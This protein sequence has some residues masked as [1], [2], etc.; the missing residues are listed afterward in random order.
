[1]TGKL[2]SLLCFLFAF[3]GTE[4]QNL[5]DFDIRVRDLISKMTIDEKISQ[6]HYQAHEISRLNIPAYNWGSECLHGVCADSVTVFPQ[7]IGLAATWDLPLMFQVS[8]AI[9]DEARVLYRKNKVGLT[10]WSPN[11]NLDRDPRWG[12]GQETYGEDPYLISRMGVAFVKGLQGEDSH[13][14][15]CV[16]GPKH[17]TAYSGPE[18]NRMEFNSIVSEC[19]LWET[20]LPPFKAVVQ[21]GNARSIMSSYYSMNG[22][23]NTADRKLLTD[24]LRNQWG[25]DGYVV[26]DCG[27]I[28]GI[29][30]GHYYT[31]SEIATAAAAINAGCDLECDYVYYRSLK[32]AL[33]QGLVKESDIDSAVFRTLKT[34]F[35]L[36][37]FDPQDSVRYTKI[38][39]SAVDS[40]EHRDLAIQAAE[41]SIVLLKNDKN[42]LPL[43]KNLNSIY[44]IGPSANVEFEFLGSY[45]GWPT[46]WT[47]VLDGI[48]KK[49]DQ[50]TMID[51][52]KGCEIVGSLTE[53]ISSKYLKTPEGQ[54]GLKGEFFNNMDLSG[55]PVLTHI[56]STINFDWGFGS[57]APEI[58]KD[59]FS[60][61]W[62]GT[63]KVDVSGEYTFKVTSDEGTR[64][65]IDSSKI[66]DDWVDHY[67][68]PKLAFCFLEAGK[69]YPI[70]LEYY[71]DFY[72]ASVKLEFGNDQ[73][74]DEQLQ[75]IT[76][77]AANSDVSIFVG[78][79]STF[80]ESEGIDIDIPGFKGGD[81]TSLDLP[82]TQEKILKALKKSGKP[83]ILVLASGSC[84]GINWEKDS[85]PAIIQAWYC[86]EEAGTAIANVLFGDYNPSGKLPITFYKS[87]DD[88]PDFEN[89]SMEGRTYRYFQKEPLYPFGYGLSYT[90]Y[91]YGNL[92]LPKDSIDIYT[93]DSIPI[94]F[95]IHNAGF[96]DGDEIVQLYFVNLDSKFPQ[97]IKQLCGFKRIH[98]NAGRFASDSI[99]L[100][101]KEL[102]YYD[103]LQH[104]FVINTGR[105]EIQVGASSQDIKLNG[106]IYI[107]NGINSFN[108]PGTDTVDRI[109]PN[110]A[111]YE[112]IFKLNSIPDINYKIR[113]YQI[114]GMEIRE[115]SNPETNGNRFKLDCSTLENGVYF[116]C[117]ENGTKRYF[118][119]F[120]IER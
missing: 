114:D 120:I 69:E 78:G 115:N 18:L 65:Y 22:I 68:V 90:N 102:A 37:M 64:L 60:V 62:T 108:S 118:K 31:S 34:R 5:Y 6:L 41:E 1:M 85:I 25:Y 117:L 98:I 3:Y 15:K 91:D 4:A 104:N 10:F 71:E 13:Y 49:I 66:L 76:D 80:Y 32:N 20:Y 81:R 47:T 12:R 19:D 30:W 26:S 50:R 23:P 44:L 57:P 86:G 27:A 33:E 112:I 75:E 36:G 17:F 38:P 97:P 61:R 72:S 100:N 107:K 16:A 51:C 89:Y 43:K 93:T 67:A 35:L 96:R 21:E 83:V 8:T 58:N 106:I 53:V 70:R 42:I 99:M 39:D 55:Y 82:L 63:I 14:L 54:P 101:L 28:I 113:L 94:G 9:S 48:K 116:I 73:T 92:V 110:P 119:K 74:G 88:L 111:N 52:Q 7:S 59:T 109:Y 40:K 87:V 29:Q 24:I 79:L 11:I 2:I 46:K 77:N 95:T 45:A 84:L 56:D 105:Y 103:T